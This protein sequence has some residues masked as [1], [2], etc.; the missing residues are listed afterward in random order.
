MG[1]R[2]LGGQA[3]SLPHPDREV[4]FELVLYPY[5]ASTNADWL[6]TEVSLFDHRTSNVFA[7]E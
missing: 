5:C 4:D 3:D 7:I 2:F 6:N 1:R